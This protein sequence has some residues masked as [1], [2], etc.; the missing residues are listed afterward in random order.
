[1]IKKLLGIMVLGL[2][3][4]ESAYA[5]KFENCYDADNLAFDPITL[6]KGVGSY[7]LNPAKKDKKTNNNSKTIDDYKKEAF[8]KYSKK[9]KKKYFDKKFYESYEFR[10]LTKNKVM[11]MTQVITDDT[12]SKETTLV[13][14]FDLKKISKF[15]IPIILATKNYLEA[16]GD[17]MLEYFRFNLSN[18]TVLVSHDRNF[19]TGLSLLHCQ[20]LNKRSNYLDYWWAVILIIA[21]TF[22][23]FTQSGKRLKQIRRK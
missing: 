12:M 22:F 8:L 21:I 6:P 13:K 3:W 19:R 23:I 17:P 4:S 9:Y 14:D 15:N 16:G 20:I 2:L 7:S 5:I 11:Q 18:G 10:L 1:M